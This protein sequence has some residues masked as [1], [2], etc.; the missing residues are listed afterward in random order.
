MPWMGNQWEQ[1][2]DNLPIVLTLAEGLANA[3]GTEALRGPAPLFILRAG[4]WGEVGDAGDLPSEVLGLADR[5]SGWATSSCK[6]KARLRETSRKAQEHSLSFPIS[7]LYICSPLWNICLAA[8]T[9]SLSTTFYRA[10]VV[11]QEAHIPALCYPQEAVL[12]Y[13]PEELL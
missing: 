6:D 7:P 11:Q 3:A 1:E 4:M 13:N 12:G 10:L 9:T 2:K 8:D 5:F